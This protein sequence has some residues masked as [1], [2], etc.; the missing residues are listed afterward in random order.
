MAITKEQVQEILGPTINSPANL[1]ALLDL[2][3]HAH[4]V[5]N[6]IKQM[7]TNVGSALITQDTF[8][9]LVTSSIHAYSL[10][11]I[12][13]QMYI[14]NPDLITTQTCQLLA[15]SGNNAFYIGMLLIQLHF[16]NPKI[17]S[18][19][20]YQTLSHLEHNAYYVSRAVRILR[21]VKFHPTPSAL[22][23]LIDSGYNAEN[24]AYAIIRKQK[25]LDYLNL[26]YR[27]FIRVINSLL[28]VQPV[29]YHFC[30]VIYQQ[31][32]LLRLLLSI[33]RPQILER[34][35]FQPHFRTFV[36]SNPGDDFVESVTFDNIPFILL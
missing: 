7:H 11:L 25:L 10:S 13:V 21:N 33:R 35:V 12:F 26:S 18:S 34:P 3:P 23:E 28:Q 20:N 22:Q 15:S 24:T 5:L 27:I 4:D 1:K 19:I 6:A 8:Q 16:L 29:L 30:N 32:D 36:G 17:I 14:T 2:G 9:A 31:L